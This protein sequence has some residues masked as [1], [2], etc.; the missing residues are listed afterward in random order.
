MPRKVLGP[1]SECQHVTLGMKAQACNLCAPKVRLDGGGSSHLHQPAWCTQWEQQTLGFQ[2]GKGKAP[3]P[4][5]PLTLTYVLWHTYTYIYTSHTPHTQLTSGVWGYLTHV[6]GV[7]TGIVLTV[8]CLGS[9]NISLCEFLV[10]PI[11]LLVNH[12]FNPPTCFSPPIAHDRLYV[13]TTVLLSP[14]FSAC[15]PVTVH[16]SSLRS[17]IFLQFRICP[18]FER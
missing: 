5:M 7:L 4:K 9:M 2:T 12:P 13:S 6:T 18:V 1:E 8:G 11:S 16:S 14:G 3:Y 10:I 17:L 15:C